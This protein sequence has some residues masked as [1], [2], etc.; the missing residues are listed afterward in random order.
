MLVTSVENGQ[1]WEKFTIVELTL[2]AIES[3]VA[4]Y[5]LCEWTQQEV[6][7]EKTK[8]KQVIGFFAVIGRQGPKLS[9][10][11]CDEVTR[12]YIAA[13]PGTQTLAD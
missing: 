4:V 3:Y 2:A 12:S 10:Q 11:R 8:P 5:E 1:Q 9:S 6:G 13:S 7:T